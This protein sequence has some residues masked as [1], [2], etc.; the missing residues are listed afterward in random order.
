MNVQTL[1]ILNLILMNLRKDKL[2]LIC[3][4]LQL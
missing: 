3:L 2:Q 4:I 1:P